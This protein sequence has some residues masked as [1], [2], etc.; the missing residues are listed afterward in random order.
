MDSRGN[1]SWCKI[2]VIQCGLTFNAK[3]ITYCCEDCH[4]GCHDDFFPDASG[5]IS[6][7]ILRGSQST[8]QAPNRHRAMVVA[9]IVLES[10]SSHCVGTANSRRSIPRR[11]M[12]FPSDYLVWGKAGAF[13]RRQHI[14]PWLAIT[15]VPHTP[16]LFS[17]AYALLFLSLE[18]GIYD[19]AFRLTGSITG[20]ATY[21]PTDPHNSECFVFQ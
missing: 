6:T 18:H 20:L 21:A 9:P 13:E 11:Q 17:R 5:L 7:S 16:F 2:V 3:G 15:E 19:A 8:N 12:A 1:H 4:A 10:I 14:P